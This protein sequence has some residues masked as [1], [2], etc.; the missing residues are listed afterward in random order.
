TSSGERIYRRK[1]YAPH[2]KGRWRPIG[3]VLAGSESSPFDKG[4]MGFFPIRTGAAHRWFDAPHP[5]H[6]WDP[7][8]CRARASSH[9]FRGAPPPGDAYRSSTCT[10]ICFAVLQMGE[11]GMTIAAIAMGD[12][13]EQKA[14]DFL[15]G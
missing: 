12:R 5:S 13:N 10:G 15:K 11:T 6:V 9:A 4:R 2:S 7:C 14:E 3:K 8:G 1:L